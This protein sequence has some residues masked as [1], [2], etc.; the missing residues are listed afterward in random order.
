MSQYAALIAAWRAKADD[1]LRA[2]KGY[3]CRSM[4]G[5]KTGLIK[6]AA[7]ARMCADDLEKALAEAGIA[8]AHGADDQPVQGED[9]AAHGAVVE[10]DGIPE[11]PGWPS[12]A[13]TERQDQDPGQLDVPS[14]QEDRP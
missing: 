9:A 13:G 5:I 10:I 14:L 12:P 7:Q 11:A 8:E 6:Q 2:A 4:E 1:L 3:P